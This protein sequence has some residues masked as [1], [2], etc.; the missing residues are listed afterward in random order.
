[1]PTYAKASE[2]ELVMYIPGEVGIMRT[3]RF[4]MLAAWHVLLN[5]PGCV[6]RLRGAITLG[7]ARLRRPQGVRAARRP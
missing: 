6:A 2:E 1:M 3:T 4:D 5:S 7:I